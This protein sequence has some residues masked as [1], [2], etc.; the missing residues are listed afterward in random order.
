MQGLF[1]VK[2][3]KIVLM[4]MTFSEKGKKNPMGLPHF[5]LGFTTPQ[6]SLPYHKRNEFG[7]WY[8]QASI[9]FDSSLVM[10]YSDDV[11]FHA[12]IE[13]LGFGIYFVYQYDY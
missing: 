4:D 12:G 11:S 13:L 5:T 7:E 1:E 2:L 6:I 10:H 9:R 3:N 8:R